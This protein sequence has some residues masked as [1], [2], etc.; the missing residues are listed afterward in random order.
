MNEIHGSAKSCARS[1]EARTWHF[2]ASS[3]ACPSSPV[4]DQNFFT[5]VLDSC[6]QVQIKSISKAKTICFSAKEIEI[7]HACVEG[8]IHAG[9]NVKRGTLGRW[10][11]NPAIVG[12][13]VGPSTHH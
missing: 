12:E 2:K 11:N 4:F 7:D 10:L 5:H 9:S 1:D 6:Q 3:V 8:F 13:V